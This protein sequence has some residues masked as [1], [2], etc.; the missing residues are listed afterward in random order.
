[1]KHSRLYSCVIALA[2]LFVAN[3]GA[4]AQEYVLKSISF[5]TPGE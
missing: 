5:L 4:M 1:M 2:M 3:L